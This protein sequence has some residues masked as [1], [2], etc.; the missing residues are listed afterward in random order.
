M[1]RLFVESLERERWDQVVSFS[2][3][4]ILVLKCAFFLAIVDVVLLLY[5]EKKEYGV[6]WI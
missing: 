4:C 2:K 5:L 3:M 6:V 1:G